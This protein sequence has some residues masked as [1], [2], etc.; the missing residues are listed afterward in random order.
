MTNASRQREL[1][2]I[3]MYYARLKFATPNLDCLHNIDTY[4]RRNFYKRREPSVS[5]TRN[6]R[7]LVKAKKIGAIIRE[8]RQSKTTW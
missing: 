1:L 4:F 5:F 7:D 6:L 8:I 2:C 3:R